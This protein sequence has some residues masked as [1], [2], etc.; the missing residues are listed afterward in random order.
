MKFDDNA[1]NDADDDLIILECPVCGEET[2]F[3]ILKYPPDA[4]VRCTEC[5][6]TM[7]TV[8]KEPKVCRVRAVVSFEHD[9]EVGTIDLIEGD[10]ISVGDYLAAD[11]GDESY[12]VE[13]TSVEVG[14]ARRNK[15]KAEK[16]DTLWTRLVD[17]V[18][19]R[20]SLNKGAVTI[21]LYEMVE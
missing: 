19:I 6:H 18:V 16:I 13:V 14:D 11:I 12:S 1:D 3:E 7:R 17:K 2:D 15:V 10:V 9:S 5:G 20:A 4:V 8:L 21:P